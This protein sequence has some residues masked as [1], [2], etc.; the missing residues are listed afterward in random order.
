MTIKAPE[1]SEF[2]RVADLRTYDRNARTHSASRG[3]DILVT[4]TQFAGAT[5]FSTDRGNSFRTYA[6][7]QRRGSR[8][9]SFGEL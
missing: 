4:W 6:L 7:G 5:W 9:Q 8:A 3:E 2:L 1:I